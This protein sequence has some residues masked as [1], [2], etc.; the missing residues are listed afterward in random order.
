M[1]STSRELPSD[2][3]IFSPATP[4]SPLCS[5]YCANPS[6]AERDCAISFSWCGKIRSRPPPW[7]SNV[8]AQVLGGHGGA[9]Q[10]PAGTARAPGGVPGGLAGL[11]ALPQREV[12]R[13]ALGIVGLGVIGGAHVIHPLA[14]QRTVRRVR[15]HV[16]VDAAV[17]GVGVPAADQPVHQGDHL[18]H[19]PGG[20]RLDVRGDA[21]QHGVRPAERPLV[22]L[23]HQP[24]R[25]AL[26]RGDPEDLVVDVG[27][28]PAERDLVSA[29]PQPPG[30]DVEDH[31]R[32]D[33]PDVR[34]RLHG[35]AAQ[36]QRH[37]PGRHR[38]EVAHRARGSV[39]K[40]ERHAAQATG[41]GGLPGRADGRRRAPGTAAGRARRARICQ[42]PA[43]L[44]TRRVPGVASNIPS[45]RAIRNIVSL[46]VRQHTHKNARAGTG[47][48]A[49]RSLVPMP[50]GAAHRRP[51][52]PAP[53]A[54]RLPV[55]GRGRDSHSIAAGR[56]T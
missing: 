1:A 20:P 16:E 4:T 6:P 56:T 52:V 22:A 25:H 33:V 54:R 5:Q 37:L 40:A 32:P 3:L 42:G 7:M 14:G 17:G 18:R 29:G 45:P 35:G 9:L 44:A 23:G 10:V 50:A 53:G 49:A 48:G 46:D 11:G 51:A 31:A 27:D 24:P 34:G 41:S 38:G 2:L 30:E 8:G 36:V 47:P 39:V 55:L 13:V 12:A 15:P 43:W 21:A 28:V 19:V 26:G